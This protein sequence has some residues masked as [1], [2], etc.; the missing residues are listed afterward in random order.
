MKENDKLE[1]AI[2]SPD[3]LISYLK[4]KAQSHNYYKLYS[5]YD[6]VIAIKNNNC[7]FLSN[8]VNWND[9]IDRN[10]FNNPEYTAENFGICFSYS[11][12]ESVAM[13][14]L[15]GGIN[16]ESAMIDFTKKAIKNILE[17]KAVKIGYFN[18]DNE[19][20]CKKTL[21][22]NEFGIFISDVIYYKKSEGKYYIKRS[23]EHVDNVDK[24][25]IDNILFCKKLYPWKY[26]NECRLIVQ[27]DKSLLDH[28]ITH[29]KIDISDIDLSTTFDRIYIGPNCMISIDDNVKKSKLTNNV[30]WDLRK[31]CKHHGACFFEK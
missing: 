22:E 16:N 4:L 7:L 8:G 23:D 24:S 18:S 29:V 2:C 27:I 9:V 30:D 28:N 17:I 5:S 19:F 10:G 25:V 11:Q 12:D 14:M 3:D 21:C 31:T 26:E 15:Y 1:N 20:V 6:K 13:W